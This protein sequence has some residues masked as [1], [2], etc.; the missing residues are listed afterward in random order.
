MTPNINI[1]NLVFVTTQADVLHEAACLS[2]H[3]RG[4]APALYDGI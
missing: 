2:N 3:L 1:A 4:T